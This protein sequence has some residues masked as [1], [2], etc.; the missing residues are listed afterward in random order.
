MKK[1]FFKIGMQYVPKNNLHKE[2]QEYIESLDG[3]LLSGGEKGVKA[4]RNLIRNKIVELN[5]KHYR[6][7]PVEIDFTY[8]TMEKSER[9]SLSSCFYADIFPVNHEL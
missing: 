3:S 8:D 5:R 2:V 4:F 9:V 7:Q 1:H 6:C